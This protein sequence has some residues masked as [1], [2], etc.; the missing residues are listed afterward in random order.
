M[1][2]LLVLATIAAVLPALGAA[3]N[4]VKKSGV[5]EAAVNH[6]QDVSDAAQLDEKDYTTHNIA[7][8]HGDDVSD[9]TVEYREGHDPDHEKKTWGQ[10]SFDDLEMERGVK[11][12]DTKLHDWFEDIRAGSVDEGRKELAVKL[13]DEEGEMQL[14][15]EIVALAKNG[16]DITV[17]WYYEEEDEDMKEAG[18]RSARKGRNPQTGKEI[19]I[20]AKKVTLVVTDDEG[21][22]DSA[23]Q[24]GVSVEGEPE[25]P[26]TPGRPVDV[27]D[28]TESDEKT[29]DQRSSARAGLE[30]LQLLSEGHA[31]NLMPYLLVHIEEGED[32]KPVV[33]STEVRYRSSGRQGGR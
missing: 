18:E 23:Q 29:N 5:R 31:Q 17:N 20:P 4:L 16:K 14:Q 9:A 33:S 7:T 2:K 8:G 6:G 10:P 30:C 24:L 28:C 27:F 3:D 32:G 15:W 12:G 26:L 21:A 19:K 13:L 25:L 11:P 1:R 22:S